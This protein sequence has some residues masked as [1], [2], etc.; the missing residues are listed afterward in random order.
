MVAAINAAGTTALYLP[1]FEDI[2]S[3]LDEHGEAG[4]VVVIV[5]SGDV[6]RQ[7]R[8]LL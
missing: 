4:D 8:K 5:G 3:W 1:T 6:Y 2:R 7:T